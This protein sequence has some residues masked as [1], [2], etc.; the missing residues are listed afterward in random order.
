MAVTVERHTPGDATMTCPVL[1]TLQKTFSC[2]S[3][4]RLDAELTY[5]TASVPRKIVHV[6]GYAGGVDPVAAIEGHHS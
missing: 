3:H 1:D 6:R 4:G 5:N 2:D